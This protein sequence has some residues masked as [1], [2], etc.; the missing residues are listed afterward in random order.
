MNLAMIGMFE[1]LFLLG[2]LGISLLIF[3]FWLW[4]LVDAI[5][6]KGLSDTEK[7]LFVVLVFFLPFIGSLIYLFVGRP[8]RKLATP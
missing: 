8:K 2:L 1:A 4:M 5:T 7:I 3:A 6:N